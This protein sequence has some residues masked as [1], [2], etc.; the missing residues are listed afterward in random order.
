MR[1][2]AFVQMRDSRME[3]S[4]C[5]L[6]AE[7]ESAMTVQVSI[8]ACIGF[9]IPRLFLRSKKQSFPA[10][11]KGRSLKVRFTVRLLKDVIVHESFVT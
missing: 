1:D 3:L 8:I 4:L 5:N 7:S 11:L 2:S 9:R 6:I 10:K